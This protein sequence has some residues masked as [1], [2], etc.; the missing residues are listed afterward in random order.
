MRASTSTV[1][2]NIGVRASGIFQGIGE[3]GKAVEGTLIVNGLSNAWKSAVV[4]G[5]DGGRDGGRAEGVAEDVMEPAGLD[6][7]FCA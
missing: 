5:K 7:R 4:P 2:K 1:L 6:I 3:D